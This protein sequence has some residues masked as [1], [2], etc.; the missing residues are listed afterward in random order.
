M[1]NSKIFKLF[2][3]FV[4]TL[5]ALLLPVFRSDA[6]AYTPSAGECVVETVSGRILSARNECERLPMA[7]T[8][9]IMTAHLV[10]KLLDVNTVVTVPRAATYAEG[11]SV[12]LKAGEKYTVLDLLYGLMLRS[13]NDAAETLAVACAGSNEAFAKKMT[14]EAILL[15]A[16]NTCFLN[17]HGL[18][19]EGHYTTAKDLALIA[20]AAM[21]DETFKKIVSTKSYVAT[22]LLSGRK[23]EWK[24]KNKLLFRF[25]GANGVKTGFTHEAGRCLVSSAERN[26]MQV[27]CVVLSS[28]QM[29]E[30]S[31][32][33]LCESFRRFRMVKIVDRERFLY[34]IPVRGTES[35]IGLTVGES[36][37]YPVSEE[38]KIRAAVELPDS[39]EWK[40]EK[41]QKAGEIKIF[42]A[43][44]LIFS[45]N[46]YTL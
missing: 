38:E 4:I 35:F 16:E 18:P 41:G 15:G 13:G 11:S 22:E 24:N 19:A 2:T 9:K 7:S 26:G 10:L 27:V 6:S 30:R 29:F 42:L 33:L 37:S 25:E 12:Y 46:I 45:Q 36:F 21:N 31:E 20:R 23:I 39:F 32:E 1:I 14:E 43:K 28:P 8:T 34:R 17:P 44:Q 5:S 40:P 3:S